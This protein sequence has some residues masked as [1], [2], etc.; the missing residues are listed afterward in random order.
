MT[1][2]P[3]QVSQQ[4]AWRLPEKDGVAS[5]RNGG[6]GSVATA[7]GDAS[8][9]LATAAT[10]HTLSIII[11]VYTE[12]ATIAAVIERIR[13]VELGPIAKEIIICDDGSWDDSPQV[14]RTQSAAASRPS[15]AWPTAF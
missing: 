7:L 5:P 13:E 14:I 3:Q 4:P 6:A 8:W 9:P 11:P 12:Q 1:A 10:T 15:R 2:L